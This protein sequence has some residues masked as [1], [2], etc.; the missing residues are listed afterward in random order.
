MKPRKLN[1][2]TIPTQDPDRAY[3]FWRDVFDIP[4]AGPSNQRHLRLDQEDLTFVVGPAQNHFELLARDHQASLRQH[5]ANNFVPIL[6]TEERYGNKIAFIV[7]DSEGNQIT[8]EV[9]Q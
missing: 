8:I 4:Q 6:K 2:K 1:H 9:N 7:N 3:R 5:L